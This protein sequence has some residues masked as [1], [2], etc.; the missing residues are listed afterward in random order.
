MMHNYDLSILD[1]VRRDHD[2]AWENQQKA[3]QSKLDAMPL[4][5]A[6][7]YLTLV[8]LENEFIEDDGSHTRYFPCVDEREEAA[9][10]RFW[11]HV[12]PLRAKRVAVGRKGRCALDR[13]DLRRQQRG[14]QFFC[15]AT[16]NGRR[17]SAFS[18]PTPFALY[19]TTIASEIHEPQSWFLQ[20]Q[21]D[22]KSKICKIVEDVVA[23]AADLRG[24]VTLYNGLG[25][26]ASIDHLHFHVFKL[27]AGHGPLPVQ[28]AGIQAAHGESQVSF[29]GDRN[30]PLSVFRFSGS[31]STVAQAASSL[32][33]QWADVDPEAATVNLIGVTEGNQTSLY[34][35][36]SRTS[37]A[38]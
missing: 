13:D 32:L 29:G 33:A 36:L 12:W 4:A 25:A 31:T 18:N 19:H 17:Y 6:L 16:L 28:E 10:K 2:G 26:G 9:P 8:H 30:Y 15:N 22:R 34:S 35:L 7:Q 23:L 1:Q 14:L 11:A 37:V 5:S 38:E 24:W 3:L 27:P 20:N 21:A